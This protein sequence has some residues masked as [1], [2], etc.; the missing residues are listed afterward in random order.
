MDKRWWMNIY[1]WTFKTNAT[2]NKNRRW[3][4]WGR[5][6]NKMA[7]DV[8]QNDEKHQMEQ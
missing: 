7:M 2:Q 6:S 3:T 8:G 5:M 4:K 1:G